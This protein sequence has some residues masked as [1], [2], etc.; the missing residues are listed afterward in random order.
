MIPYAVITGRVTDPNGVPI[1]NAAVTIQIA[2]TKRVTN[3]QPDHITTCCNTDD[4]GEFRAS[5][6]PPGTFYVGAVK[7]M[8]NN[9]W[10]DKW[11]TTWFPNALQTTSATPLRLKAGQQVRADIQVLQRN[12]ARIAGRVTAPDAA[13]ND[14]EL[15][16]STRLQLVAEKNGPNDPSMMATLSG[17]DYEFADVLPGRYVLTALSGDI[18]G[19]NPAYGALR[20]IE[21]GE[22]GN[23]ALN[24][25]LRPLG[26][27]SGTVTVADGCTADSVRIVAS[28]FGFTGLA[29]SH[30]EAVPANDGSFT[31]SGLMPAT[32]RIGILQAGPSPGGTPFLASVR[33]GDR[34]VFEDGLDY[35]TATDAPLK[36]T[37]G[38]NQPGR[39]K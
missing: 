9:R 1:V 33:L 26:A 5:G 16:M 7:T 10:Q 38:C 37:L 23:V 21:I 27:I 20:R 13:A 14:T 6:L 39:S 34:D 18:Y 8:A 22:Q 11:R 32:L 15:S 25:A 2:P 24:I 36:V 12:G 29:P 3:G 19:Q 30:A 35:P 17:N 4:R 28:T 31:L